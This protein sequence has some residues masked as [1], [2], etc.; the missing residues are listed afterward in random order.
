MPPSKPK[1]WE[2]RHPS[3]RKKSGRKSMITERLEPRGDGLRLSGG[4]FIG[5]G[6]MGCVHLPIGVIE[7]IS[8][9][10]PSRFFECNPPNRSISSGLKTSS[11][12][13][14]GCEEPAGAAARF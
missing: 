6:F 5:I 3:E 2:R 7:G 4:W 13:K 1:C 9:D 14:R 11:G 10:Y 8:Y 12:G